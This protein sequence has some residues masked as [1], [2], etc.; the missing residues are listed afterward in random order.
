MGIPNIK[1]E[2][3]YHGNP[4]IWKDGLYLEMGPCSGLTN[5]GIWA[6]QI[7]A[8][9]LRNRLGLLVL[10]QAPREQICFI[11]LLELRKCHNKYL[12]DPS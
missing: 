9:M 6:D 4:Y 1:I 8:A 10:T 3:L 5:I 12:R 2:Y 7:R 11:S